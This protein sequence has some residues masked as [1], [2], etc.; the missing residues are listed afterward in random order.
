MARPPTRPAI[1]TAAIL[2]VA[3]A[4]GG[5]A[6]T[7]ATAPRAVPV[8]LIGRTSLDKVVTP[9]L[10][11]DR[12]TVR[13]S[14]VGSGKIRLVYR[15]HPKSGIATTRFTITNA[16]GT[17]SGTATSRYAVTRLHITFTGAGSI[18]RG[19]GSYRRIRGRPLAFDAVHSLTGKREVIA[20]TGRAT[21]P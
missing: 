8:H 4:A 14:P 7:A 17:V 18:T 11:V 12:G 1:A 5:L 16:R 13:G 2:A 21:L 19:T 20:F 3:A 10:L 6:A 9:T 15:L